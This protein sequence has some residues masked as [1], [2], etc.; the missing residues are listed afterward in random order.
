MLAVL[1][2]HLAIPT[3]VV[4]HDHADADALA[5]RIA[6]MD[7]GRIKQTGAPQDVVDHPVNAY[8]AQFTGANV[9]PGSLLDP[10]LNPTHWWPWIRLCS[11][12]TEIRWPRT[13]GAR[14]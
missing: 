8:V 11:P 2:H 4:T 7:R 9:I 12:W 1:L 14:P 5:D 6:V 10:A 3:V 13:A